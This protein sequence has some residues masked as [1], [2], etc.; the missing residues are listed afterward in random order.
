MALIDLD[1]E[2]VD[3]LRANETLTGVRP[4]DFIRG[5]LRKPARA[6][7][8]MIRRRNGNSDLGVFLRILKEIHGRYSE[9][10]SA[11]ES[12]RGRTRLYFSTNPKNIEGSGRSMFPVEIPGTGW[13]VTSN[14]ST[15]RKKSILDEVFRAVG[16][17]IDDQHRW[18][19]GFGGSPPMHMQPSDLM[20]DDDP[21]KI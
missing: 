5:L 2:I 1:G 11:V 20:E 21:F 4:S 10:F 7:E 6:K 18:L 13:W 15:D 8:P 19:G 16:C 9:K 3:F 12:V 14:T 17:S